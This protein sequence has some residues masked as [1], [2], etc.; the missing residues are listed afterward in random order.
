MAK[1][2]TRPGSSFS[3][4]R[5]AM[6][7]RPRKAVYRVFERHRE[8]MERRKSGEASQLRLHPDRTAHRH[9]RTRHPRRDRGLL[10]HRSERSEQAG[11]V[12]RGRE[13][14][15]DCSRRVP[16][17][18]TSTV[19][20]DASTDSACRTTCTAT[21]GTTNGYTI[22]LD[23][24]GKVTVTIGGGNRTTSAT[25]RAAQ[26]SRSN[27][28]YANQSARPSVAG[29]FGF[30]SA[31]IAS[32][33]RKWHCDLQRTNRSLAAGALGRDMVRTCSSSVVRSRGSG[34]TEA[35]ARLR[36]RRCSRAPRSP[37]SSTTC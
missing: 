11:R 13:V 26:P 3:A 29:R 7:A 33:E 27:R 28:S 17:R 35:C 37:S 21:P 16:G 5:R 24:T 12:H 1:W 2:R 18:R 20:T 9:C 36:A 22:G 15:R 4:K 25:L 19:A 32:N 10:P 6:A 14:G 31:D 23:A 34:S 8:I 30:A